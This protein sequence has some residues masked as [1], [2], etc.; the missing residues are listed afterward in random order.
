MVVVNARIVDTS[1]W[2]Q[3]FKA[4]PYLDIDEALQNG[5]VYLSPIIIAELLSGK[6]PPS[7]KAALVDFL[8]ELPLVSVEFDHWIRVGELRRK[9]AEKGLS[10][11]TP[12]AH[13]AQCCIDI[14]A[15]LISEDLIFKKLTKIVPTLLL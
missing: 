11:S 8:R 12:D 9:A 10:L 7:K 15:K 6:L 14:G 13:I 2:I 5:Q 1:S 3:Y 4:K